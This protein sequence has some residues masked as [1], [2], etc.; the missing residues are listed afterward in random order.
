MS[1]SDK[2]VFNPEGKTS[3]PLTY[4]NLSSFTHHWKQLYLYMKFFELYSESRN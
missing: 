3:K 4:E 2:L 1:G